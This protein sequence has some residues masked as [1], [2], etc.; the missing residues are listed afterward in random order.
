MRLGGI[1]MPPWAHVPVGVGRVWAW[2]TSTGRGKAWSC[3]GAG[4]EGDRRV[5]AGGREAPEV[6]LQQPPHP[7]LGCSFW[8]GGV[9]SSHTALPDPAAHMYLAP[10]RPCLWTLGAPL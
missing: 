5:P 10:P 9:V 8:E 3:Q 4:P 2:R 6:S 7:C 1:F